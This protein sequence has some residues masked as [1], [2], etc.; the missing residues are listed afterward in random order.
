MSQDQPSTVIRNLAPESQGSNNQII[1]GEGTHE[2]LVQGGQMVEKAT[3]A[4]SDP[5]IVKRLQGKDQF[6]AL[7]MPLP[8]LGNPTLGFR[9]R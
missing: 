1:E 8:S 7:A 9:T 5:Q 6:Q 3:E 4:M 2:S